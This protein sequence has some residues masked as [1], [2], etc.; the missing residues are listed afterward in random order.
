[1]M[2]II[3]ADDPGCCPDPSHTPD[4]DIGGFCAFDLTSESISAGKFCWDQQPEYNAY[5]ETSFGHG[6]L[7]VKNDTYALWRWLRN[8]EFAEFAGDNVFIVREPERDL[9]SSQRN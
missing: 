4:T 3:R 6:I 8:L 5:R 7:E 2:A 9:L 1:M